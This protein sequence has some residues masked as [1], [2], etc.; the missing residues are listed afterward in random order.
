MLT[1]EDLAL[2][3]GRNYAHFVTLNPDG[4]AHA[5]PIWIDAEDDGTILVNTAVGRR[6][7]R[8]VRRDPR[9]VVSLHAQDD[10]YRW[11]SVN[12]TV[13]DMI[14]GAEGLAHIDALAHRYDDRSWTPV[15]G[16]LR[17]IYRISPDRV[18]R[19]D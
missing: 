11:L 17:V 12:G 8:N 2:L 13:T 16:Q 6:K 7:D 4:S 9:V 19:S 14:E 10:P 1:P 18:L 15:E 5:S 3:R